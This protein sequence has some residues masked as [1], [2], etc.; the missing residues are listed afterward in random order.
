MRG[1]K[2]KKTKLGDKYGKTL[3]VLVDAW[4]KISINNK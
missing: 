3:S 2:G 1:G 4:V